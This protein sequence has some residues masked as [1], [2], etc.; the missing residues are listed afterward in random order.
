M[1][2]SGPHLLLLF[3]FLGADRLW[4]CSCMRPKPV[5]AY[6]D[7]ASVIFLGKVASTEDAGSN[8]LRTRFE[9]QEA[10]KGLSPDTREFWI[11][12]DYSICD[13]GYKVGETWLVVA[14]RSVSLRPGIPS[15]EK[16]KEV[17][18]AGQC[19][20]GRR[21]DWIY[22]VPL[23]SDID[24]LRQYKAG[25]TGS[26]VAGIVFE[27]ANDDVPGFNS[28]I[29]GA[30]VILIGNGKRRVAR[31]GQDG[32]FFFN[33]LPPGEYKLHASLAPYKDSPDK[34]VEVPATGCDSAYLGIGSPGVIEGLVFDHQNRRVG[35]IE[36][37]LVRLGKDG[38]PMREGRKHAPT[39]SRGKFLFEDLPSGNYEVGVNLYGQPGQ[40][41]PYPPTKW[42]LAGRDSIPLGL[43]ERKQLSPLKLPSPLEHRLIEVQVRW[44]SG[45]AAKGID[46]WVIDN[47]PLSQSPSIK[48]T[49]DSRGLARLP[50]VEN[51]AYEI[52]A[53]IWDRQQQF[54]S[55][56]IRI[57]SASSPIKMNL[58]LKRRAEDL[59]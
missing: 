59:H 25:M 44:P 2:K 39:D 51:T 47:H 30:N 15:A 34:A 9:V 38:K 40:T 5:C 52:E 46:V 57:E 41:I 12:P 28:R 54:S 42:R 24:Y 43:A 7:H 20:G 32:L 3:A 23:A 10:F 22:P 36:V 27:M 37:A 45:R 21:S 26:L 48:S 16:P 33:P 55:G 18:V 56:K 13:E 49:T 1:V 31:S 14:Q 35:N 19:S 58:T 17:Y 4:P 50:L 53:E 29:S 8:R 11:D 6:V